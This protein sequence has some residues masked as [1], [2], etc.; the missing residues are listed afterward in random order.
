[1]SAALAAWPWKFL[2]GDICFA[3]QIVLK[4]KRNFHINM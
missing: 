3:V 1:M 2:Q 4:Y